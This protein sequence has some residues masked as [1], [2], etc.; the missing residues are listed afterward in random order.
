MNLA[1]IKTGLISLAGRRG[2]QIQKASPEI[3]MTLGIAGV[4]T[5]TVLAC[6][7][8]LKVDT[9]LDGHEE[10]L[11]KID[12]ALALAISENDPDLYTDK[13]AQKDLYLTYIQTAAEFVKLYAPSAILGAASIACLLGSHRIMKGRNVALAAAYKLLDEGFDSYRARV[14]EEHGEQ[15]DYMYK[16][17][18]R[19]EVV[20][21]EEPTGE[22]GKTKKV[23][24][25]KLRPADPNTNSVYAR[26][27]DESCGAWSPQPEYN[28]M[29]L[30]AQQSYHNNILQVRGHVF[31]NEV[32][33]AL[34]IPRTQAGQVV[35][36]CL[37]AGGDD[38]VDF[39]IFDG[40]RVKARDFVNGYE[41]SILLDFN[42]DG[43]I[44]NLI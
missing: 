19:A 40:D 21:E 30:R 8:T 2:L 9:V 25:N 3:L 6:K 7:A 1:T 4:I 24:K 32:Y 34:G 13:D 16:N 11:G 37:G 44:H 20:T 36:W 35:G 31:L 29:F 15:T 23:K 28:M 27:F 17:G 14:R 41:Q 18:M 12:K 5:S 10:K 42:V 26:W 22:N 33:D 38:F 39:G 43:V